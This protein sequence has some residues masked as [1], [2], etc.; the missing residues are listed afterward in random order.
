MLTEKLVCR[1]SAGEVWTLEGWGR[2]MPA[3]LR[4]MRSVGGGTC[5]EVVEETKEL[6]TAEGTFVLPEGHDGV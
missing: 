5:L 3:K 6:P 1:T 4:F 2:D